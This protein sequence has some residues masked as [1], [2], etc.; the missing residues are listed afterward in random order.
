MNIDKKMLKESSEWGI[1]NA[2]SQGLP[3]EILKGIVKNARIMGDVMY[4]SR[5]LGIEPKSAEYD[6]YFSDTRKRGIDDSVEFAYGGSTVPSICGISPYNTPMDV[7]EDM[8]GLPKPSDN[9][10]D[11]EDIFFA[12]HMVEPMYREY[13]RRLYSEKENR[14]TVIDTDLQFNSRKWPHFVMNVDGLLIERETGKLGILEIKHTDYRNTRTIGTFQSGNV[15]KHYEAQGRCYAEGLGA[16]FVV[17]VLGWGL[18]PNS[19]C[20]TTVRIERDEAVAEALLDNC[21][22][23]IESY[24]KR[25]KMPPLNSIKDGDLLRKNLEEYFGPVDRKESPI[26]FDSK[27]F[28]SN[29]VALLDAEEKVEEAKKGEKK[30]KEKV[31]EATKKYEEYQIAFIEELGTAPY[32]YIEDADGTNYLIAYDVQNGVNVDKLV[33]EHPEVYK[34][35]Q[36]PAIDTAALKKRFPEIYRECYEPKEGAKRKFT[37]KKTFKRRRK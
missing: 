2:M 13:F 34:K 23:F 14:Y 28:G 17:F 6:Q 15:P 1:K 11:K 37:I 31:D 3:K 5:E 8:L 4:V 9:D 36:K 21:E 18:R 16:D 10:E 27:K 25:R 24:V 26:T 32:G 20:M 29:L 19:N 33:D 30:A 12:G 7:Y 22:A 35:V